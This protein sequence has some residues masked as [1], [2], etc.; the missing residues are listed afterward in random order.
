MGKVFIHLSM[1]SAA[2]FIFI[3]H[4]Y[5][6]LFPKVIVGRIDYILIYFYILYNIKLKIIPIVELI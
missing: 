3:G 5:H 4:C 1:G 6:L 2:K